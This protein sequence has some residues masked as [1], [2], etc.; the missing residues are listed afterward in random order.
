VAGRKTRPAGQP[1]RIR[2]FELADTT[3]ALISFST[4]IST[5][6]SLTDA[7]RRIVG[8]LLRG[9]SDREIARLRGT[10]PRTVA[11]QLRTLFRKLGVSSRAELVA[12]LSRPTN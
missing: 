2:R 12:R 1:L 3:L 4:E 10:S 5:P 6:V 8:Q 11:N 7:E 9:R